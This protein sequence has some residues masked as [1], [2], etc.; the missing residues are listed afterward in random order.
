MLLLHILEVISEQDPARLHDL[1]HSF[2]CN[3]LQRW[4][5]HGADVQTKLPH[6]ATYL[7]HV[8]VTCTYWYLTA[9]PE[10]MAI[11]ARRF[12]RYADQGGLQ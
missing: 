3:A 2:A 6:P 11:T 9:V 4:Y 5:T 10:L 12:E 8:N 1:R 7:G